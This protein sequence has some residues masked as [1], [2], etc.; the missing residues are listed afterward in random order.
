MDCIFCKIARGEIPSEVL[1]Q[2]GRALVIRDINPQAPI[3]LLIMPREHLD[4]L[5]DITEAN[6]S[7]INHMV[8]L[9]NRMAAREGVSEKGYRLAINCGDEGGQTVGH[10]HMHLLGGRALSGRLG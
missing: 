10:L 4:S 7:L 6:A 3:H 8:L 9:A 5:M 1:H 2:D